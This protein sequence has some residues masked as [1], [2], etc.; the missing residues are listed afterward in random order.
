VLRS[1]QNNRRWR[2]FAFLVG[3]FL[4]GALVWLIVDEIQQW[5][6][7]QKLEAQA[8]EMIAMMRLE[9]I[10]DFHRRIDT[11]RTFLNDHSMHK[12][13]AAFWRNR[14]DK[15]AFAAGVIAHAKNPMNEPV[16]MECSTRSNLMG[17]VL[18][19]LGYKT[20]RVDIYNTHPRPRP[21]PGVKLDSHSFLEVMSPATA[22]WETQDVDYD[23]YW[24][25]KASHERISIADSAENVDEVEPCGRTMCGWDTVSREGIR[26]KRLRL[27]LDII[28][29]ST[30][31]KKE[32]YA[33]YTTRADLETIYTKGANQGSF[34]EVQAK[35]CKKGFRDIRNFSTYG[36][37]LPR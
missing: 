18:R 3:V 1:V 21:G 26:A 32:R 10:T 37:N 9:E 22:R 8:D 19:K 29:I 12:I 33:F 17:R 35:R 15:T 36:A 34:C 6:M 2:I 23:I 14:A 11:I 4:L 25:N 30:E 28:S 31:G 13:D 7:G 5:R 20:R 27:Y 24:R 16:H